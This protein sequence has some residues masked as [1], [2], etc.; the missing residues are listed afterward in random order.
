MFSAA[1]IFRSLLW[2]MNIEG[3]PATL[4][5]APTLQSPVSRCQLVYLLLCA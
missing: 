4:G 5:R 2:W 1:E 3:L